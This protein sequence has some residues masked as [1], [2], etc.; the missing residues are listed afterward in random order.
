[1][2][3]GP[4]SGDIRNGA[5]W[6]TV[7]AATW[8]L[9]LLSAGQPEKG[10]GTWRWG[11]HVAFS[12]GIHC[13][14]AGILQSL[15]HTEQTRCPQTGILQL[16]CQVQGD[17]FNVNAWSPATLIFQS[18]GYECASCRPELGHNLFSDPWG[19]L[20]TQATKWSRHSK[21][22]PRKLLPPTYRKRDNNSNPSYLSF[23]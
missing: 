15:H 13:L 1:M 16:F 11:Q 23:L 7:S 4:S 21:N 8:L 6:E 20:L 10:V 22:S 19:I 3:P 14:G 9:C 5:P 2:G 17:A 12:C 18:P